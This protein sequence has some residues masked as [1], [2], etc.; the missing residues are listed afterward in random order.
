LAI[1]LKKAGSARPANA[2]KVDGSVKCEHLMAV[3]G[4]YL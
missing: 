2:A 4:P 1:R 3:D